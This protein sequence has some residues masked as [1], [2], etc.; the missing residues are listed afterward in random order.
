MTA[1]DAHAAVGAT[2]DENC[3]AEAQRAQCRGAAPL[4]PYLFAVILGTGAWG[5]RGTWLLL[6]LSWLAFATRVVG[7]TAQSL[8]RD[9]VDALRFATQALPA[10]LEMFRRPGENGPLFFLGL[11]PWL[12]V[13]GTSEFALRFPSAAMAALSVPVFYALM[14]RLV[15]AR[16]TSAVAA[17]LLA[18]APYGIWYGQEAKMYAALLLW[19][20]AG[21]YLTVAASWQGG[22]WRWALLYGMT[23]AGFYT[24]LL[25]ALVVP[26][27]AI[28]LMILPALAAGRSAEW[29]RRRR[30]VGLLYLA[31]LI[32]PYL[33]LARWQAPMW[34]A[35]QTETGYP[36]VPL[37]MILLVQLV[38]FGRGILPLTQPIVLLP[39]AV[40]LLAGVVLWPFL[41]RIQD[42]CDIRRGRTGADENVGAH[43][44]APLPHGGRHFQDRNAP[45]GA[46]RRWLLVGLLLAWLLLPAIGIYVISLRRPLFADR[47]LIWT[48]PAFLGLVGLGV[49]AL[50]RM[51]R[52][53]GAALLAALVAL[54]LAAAAGQMAQPIKSDFRAAAAFVMAHKQPGDRLLFQIPYNRYTFSYYSGELD[55]WLDG[56]YTNHGMSEAELDAQMARATADLSAVWL[57]ASEVPMWDA[58]G[59]TEAWLAAHGTVM[60]RAEFA[61]VTVTRYQL[62]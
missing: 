13:A 24:H 6:A 8:W 43:G 20:C 22:W 58:R 32:G 57:I 47:Y 11:R 45:A 54:N 37:P 42:R 33:P 7:L 55:G 10:L 56:P 49:S 14:R 38:A 46:A 30:L 36:F 23:G 39:T 5:R 29:A 18:T 27:Q 34:L 35:G 28:W 61:R 53:L 15:C 17:L 31:L 1:T 51:L 50:R 62:R 26:V 21:M 16:S 19:I 48:M 9:E 4:R 12:A 25:A 41:G 60:Q 44:R 59:L 52:P 2:A 3:T 40:A